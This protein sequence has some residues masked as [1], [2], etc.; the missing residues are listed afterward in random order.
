[1]CAPHGGQH[2]RLKPAL[3]SAVHDLH[4]SASHSA[5]GVFQMSSRAAQFAAHL[6][7]FVQGVLH[8]GKGALQPLLQMLQPLFHAYSG[9][10]AVQ[11]RY[12]RV[13][14][15]LQPVLHALHNFVSKGRQPVPRILNHPFQ[16]LYR[17]GKEGAGR[18]LLFRHLGKLGFHRR[19]LLQNG[20]KLPL[21]AVQIPGH[22]G[23][24]L[25]LGF[26]AVFLQ[27]LQKLLERGSLFHIHSRSPPVSPVRPDLPDG[28]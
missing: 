5:S 14:E 1:M 10:R 27:Q 25:P 17:T 13:L 26:S 2:S 7:H 18:S 22:E 16:C 19:Q 9:N 3:L 6:L 28:W 24:I 11:R 4:F 12:A 8:P 21:H 23:Q 15:P 20:V